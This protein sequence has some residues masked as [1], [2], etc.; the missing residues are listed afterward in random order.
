MFLV[1]AQ[2]FGPNFQGRLLYAYI[3]YAML[4]LSFSFRQ[5][6]RR[7]GQ[8]QA[9]L[10]GDGGGEEEEDV[11]LWNSFAKYVNLPRIKHSRVFFQV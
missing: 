2:L 5:V 1:Y 9:D 11:G 6:A 10:L 4:K 7:E 3:R 8:E